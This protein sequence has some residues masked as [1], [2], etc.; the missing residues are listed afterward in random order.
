MEELYRGTYVEVVNYIENEVN[1][2]CENHEVDSARNLDNVKWELMSLKE[3]GCI[4]DHAEIVLM[5]NDI[6]GYTYEV[7][8]EEMTIYDIVK[9]TQKEFET[10][11]S[12][13]AMYGSDT[14]ETRLLTDVELE[15]LKNYMSVYTSKLIKNIKKF[16]NE[17]E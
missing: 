3:Q 4:T 15:I 11:L 7:L 12:F 1:E 8:D 14:Q 10:I 13:G 2:M 5:T 16:N 17:E 6:V 9:D